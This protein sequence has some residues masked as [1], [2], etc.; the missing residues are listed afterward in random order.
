M[1]KNNKKDPQKKQKHVMVIKKKSW[2]GFNMFNGS[3]LTLSSGLD[4]GT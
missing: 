3:N 2:E 1:N 4:Q